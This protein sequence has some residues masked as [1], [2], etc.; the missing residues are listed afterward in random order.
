MMP[1]ANLVPPGMLFPAAELNGFRAVDSRQGD[2]GLLEFPPETWPMLSPFRKQVMTYIF[3]TAR[4]LSGGLLDSADVSVSSV[5]DEVDTFALDLT[6]VFNA[7][8]DVIHNLRREILSRVSEWSKEW[9]D[10]ELRDYGR[11]IY[12][13]LMPRE[14]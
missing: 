12:F 6:L 11:R 9:S 10:E 7:D 5:V 13:G 14:I 2:R 8:W 4:A 1:Q 3:L